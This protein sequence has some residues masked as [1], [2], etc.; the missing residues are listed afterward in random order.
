MEGGFAH[1]VDLVR[2]IREQYGDYFGIGVAGTLL[3]RLV[4]RV[5]RA[6]AAQP[7]RAPPLVIAHAHGAARRQGTRRATQRPSPRKMT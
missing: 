4:G 2:Y 3:P 5:P 1:A 7:R 6:H